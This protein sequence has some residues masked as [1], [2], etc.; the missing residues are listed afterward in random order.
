M[1]FFLA[2]LAWLVIG[3]ILVAGIVMATKGA[4]WLLILGLLA[5]A[6]AFARWGCATQ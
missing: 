6:A 1:S 5:F 4:M 3:A 2:V